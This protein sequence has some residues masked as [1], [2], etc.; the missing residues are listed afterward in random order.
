M[1]AARE[2]GESST[3][4]PPPSGLGLLRRRQLRRTAHTLPALLRPAAALGG[5]GADKIALHVGE[6]SENGN[7]QAPGAGASVSPRLGKRPELRLGVHD[8]LDDGEQI[9]GAAREAV[10]A[11]HG[12]HVTGGR[13]Q[14]ARGLFNTL[15]CAK[16]EDDLARRDNLLDELRALA[17][18]YSDDAAVR[19]LARSYPDDGT[20]RELLLALENS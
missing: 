12:H 5:A 17:R 2:F 16:A 7:H 14:L 6:S 3:L 9:E 4:R 1:V 11:R 18:S 8:L 19:A 20:V 10:D 15:Y 13:D